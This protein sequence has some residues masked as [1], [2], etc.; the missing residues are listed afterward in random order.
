MTRFFLW[1]LRL[2]DKSAFMCLWCRK[3]RRGPGEKVYR[4]WVCC[5]ECSVAW[6]DEDEA[7]YLK[8]ARRFARHT[9][10]PRGDC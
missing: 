5:D 4:G 7:N 3:L 2:F 6:H 8:F 10:L 1:L 9:P